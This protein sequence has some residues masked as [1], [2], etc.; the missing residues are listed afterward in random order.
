MLLTYSDAFTKENEETTSVTAIAP[1]LKTKWAQ[2][3][4]FNDDCPTNKRATDGSKCYSGCVATAMAQVMNYHKFPSIGIGYHAYF[5]R[6]QNYFQAMKF[7]NTTFNWDNLVD[8]YS[9][10][11]TVEQN[12]E[13]AKLMHA[14]GIAVSMNYGSST[15][16]QSGAYPYDIPYAMINYFGYNPNVVYRAKDYYTHDEWN[17]MIIQELQAGRPILYSGSGTGGHEFILDGCDENGLYH[18]CFGQNAS[19]SASSIWYGIGDGYYSLDA[20]SLTDSRIKL[21]ELLSGES[22][23]ELGNYTNKQ[24]M[25][26]QISPNTVGIHEDVFYASRF[27]LSAYSTKHIGDKISGSLWATNYSSSTSSTDSYSPTFNGEIGIGLF[28]KNFNF[29]E[30]LYSEVFSKNSADYAYLSPSITLSED[31]FANGIQYIIAPYAKA[32]NSDAPTRIR[33][34]F[35]KG[36]YLANV[37]EGK[38]AL[39]LNGIP[40]LINNDT[41]IY[42]P[43]PTGTIY[44][45]A[46]G[47]N[48]GLV[49]DESS[50][51][52]IWQL[53]LT[54]DT[55]DPAK[56]WFD[57]IDPAVS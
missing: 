14:C 2:D 28:D 13:V 6:T 39:T 32:T 10:E 51:P 22:I 19:I 7:G 31:A 26:C 38:V 52:T 35:G 5:S 4:P 1:L 20:I 43:I 17:E 34:T 8:T 53:T 42:K 37:N 50:K 3:A 49:K 21:L 41:V 15:D 56:Y 27:S 16:G 23:G 9:D 55:E 48:D 12:A 45:S 40:D 47:S 29:I 36:W 46:L 11:S 25:V 18:F 33:T 57:N 44:A 30:S 54:K 24:D